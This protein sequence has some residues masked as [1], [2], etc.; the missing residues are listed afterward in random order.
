MRLYICQSENSS[1]LVISFK[2]IYYK[3]VVKIYI[4]HIHQIIFINN[5]MKINIYNCVII[6][7]QVNV[8]CKT[9]ILIH[10]LPSVI[11]RLLGELF[12]LKDILDV[13]AVR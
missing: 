8:K 9:Y 10:I 6:C 5:N 12:A 7:S 1:P 4:R 13:N 3:N 11:T 2:N